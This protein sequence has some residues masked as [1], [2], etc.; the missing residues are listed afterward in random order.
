[1]RATCLI[2]LGLCGVWSCNDRC[3]GAYHC[4]AGVTSITLPSDISARVMSATGDTC[5]A[6]TDATPGSIFLTSAT[7]KPCHIEIRL[8]DGTTRSSTVTFQSLDDCC[9]DYT[10]TATSFEAVDGGAGG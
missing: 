10:A 9:N 6:Q 2:L 4:L 3:S 7:H 8:D 1:M 5:D